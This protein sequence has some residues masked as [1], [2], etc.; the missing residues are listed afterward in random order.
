MSDTDSDDSN[1]SDDDSNDGKQVEK[2]I[3]KRNEYFILVEGRNEE[4]Q[5]E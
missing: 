4:K 5:E 2:L 1:G 3:E